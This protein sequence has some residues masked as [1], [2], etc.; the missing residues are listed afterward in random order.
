MGGKLKRTSAG[1]AFALGLMAHGV[2]AAAAER[3]CEAPMSSGASVGTTEADARAGAIVSWRMKTLKTYGQRHADWG[4]AAE[5]IT[6]CA[7]RSDGGFECV[8]TA[9]ACTMQ[10]GGGNTDI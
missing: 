4:L 3:I 7:P 6:K 2:S 8:T 1:V 10:D 9:R 5:K